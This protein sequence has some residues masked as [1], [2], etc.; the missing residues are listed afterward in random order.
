MVLLGGLELVA[1]GYLIHQYDENK[2]EKKRIEEERRRRRRRPHSESPPR[3]R[4]QRRDDRPK[5]DYRPSD[6]PSAYAPPPAQPALRPSS[7][8]PGRTSADNLAVPGP[9]GPQRPSSQPPPS[10]RPPVG[11]TAPTM[12]GHAPYSQAPPSGPPANYPYSY[13]PP[14][15]PPQYPSAVPNASR[16]P[17]GPSS[18][19]YM[20][21]TGDD[22][23]TY[24]PE[25]DDPRRH[26]DSSLPLG[27]YEPPTGPY[28]LSAEGPWMHDQ[29]LTV[30][31]RPHV[32]FNIPGEGVANAGEEPRSPPPA[33][34]P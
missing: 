16:P 4:P 2:K 9:S 31:Q 14:F 28:E 21:Y 20:P 23:Y 3:N 32:R 5:H 7:A 15:S 17:A 13:P 12:M 26:S 30:H 8:G 19:S 10:C 18:G 25:V 24:S 22:K 1:A 34:R 6:R 11:Y 29:N 33:Y 27:I